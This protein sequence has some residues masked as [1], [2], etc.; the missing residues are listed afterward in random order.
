MPLDWKLSSKK[1][2]QNSQTRDRTK[3]TNW[4]NW[5]FF[6]T[7]ILGKSN[8]KAYVLNFKGSKPSNSQKTEE[9][10]KLDFRVS[11]EKNHKKP[12]HPTETLA[13]D[14]K[15]SRLSLWKRV[16]K[17]WRPR[18]AYEGNVNDQYHQSREEKKTFYRIQKLPK[19]VPIRNQNV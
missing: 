3:N 5:F 8:H 4:R 12:S 6:I 15:F 7:S 11:L 1:P 10:L 19:N 16:S 14:K 2:I 17:L 18:W 9:P 13:C